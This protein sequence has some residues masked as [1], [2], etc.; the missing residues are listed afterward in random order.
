M[1]KDA[2]KTFADKVFADMAGA[3]TAGMG[4]WEQKPRCFAVWLAGG[5]CTSTTLCGNRG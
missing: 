5:R 1:D 4:T 3:M 2:V